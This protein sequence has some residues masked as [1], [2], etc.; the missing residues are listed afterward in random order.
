MHIIILVPVNVYHDDYGMYL[1]KSTPEE[2]SST[3]IDRGQ[4]DWAD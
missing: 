2:G 1:N 4:I 3:L